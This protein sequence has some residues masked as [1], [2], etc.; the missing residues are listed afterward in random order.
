ME[1]IEKIQN[2]VNVYRLD[3]NLV[4]LA[5]KLFSAKP[6]KADSSYI[7]TETRFNER[8]EFEKAKELF[9][10]KLGKRFLVCGSPA[11]S[12]YEGGEMTVS[13][14]GRFV[15]PE[16][17]EVVPCPS[18]DKLTFGCLNTF[19]ETE[20]LFSYLEGKDYKSIHLI[21]PQ[22]HYLRCFISAVSVLKK[23][24][25]KIKIIPVPANSQDWNENVIHSQGK[26][27][28]NREQLVSEE[29]QRIAKYQKQGN[30]LS[31]SE[32]ISYIDSF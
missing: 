8:I 22:F 10:R 32:V 14:L 19:S 2:S 21:S 12:G 25:S 26:I 27:I 9:E 11:V 18:L 17:I 24:G 31:A 7:Y 13:M 30:L 29:L 23:T 4:T 16:S 15:P 3:P 5:S 28:A 6:E 20:S 1:I